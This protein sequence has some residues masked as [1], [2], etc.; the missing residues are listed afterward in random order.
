MVIIAHIV[1]ES[2]VCHSRQLVLQPDS[3]G[4]V[5]LI[6]LPCFKLLPV[7]SFKAHQTHNN[8]PTA[9]AIP[10]LPSP[11]NR[12]CDVIQS[13]FKFC[14]TTLNRVGNRLGVNSN[15][16]NSYVVNTSCLLHERE[17]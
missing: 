11:P 17:M 14:V 7:R 9:N 1:L 4:I 6:L 16:V 3:E 2:Q 13:D 8:R 15:T 5:I 10:M 12:R